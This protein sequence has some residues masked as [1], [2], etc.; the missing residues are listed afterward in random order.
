MKLS[1]TSLGCPAWDLQKMLSTAKTLGYDGIDFR[2]YL[3]EVELY[4]R[5]E[6]T[7]GIKDTLRMV[8]K[9]GLEVSAVSSSVKAFSKNDEDRIKGL[10]D[11][12]E[13]VKIAD[14]LNCPYIR[15]FGGG[16]GD[17]PSEKA[18]QV[19]TENVK[20]MVKALSGARANIIIETH[21]E[22]TDSSKLRAIVDNVASER[23]FVL[24]DVHHP[25]RM[26]GETPAQTWKNIGDKVRYTHFKDSIG[27]ADGKHKYTLLGKGDVPLKEIVSCLKKGGYTGYL[28]LEWE[29]RWHAE[30]EEPEVSLPQYIEEMRKI[31]KSV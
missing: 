20:A 1:F 18:L 12:K 23:L 7:S 22:W 8:E 17:T 28:T 30:L 13:Y 5:P 6:F 31:L 21:D 2:G 4:K 16:I 11:F 15:I 24:W 19:A 27:T 25:Y 29:K 14:G 9:N 26:N 3:T 10:S